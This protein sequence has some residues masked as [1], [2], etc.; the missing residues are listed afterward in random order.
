MSLMKK[1]TGPPLDSGERAAAV[2]VDEDPLGA[3]RGQ[4]DAGAEGAVAGGEGDEAGI[5]SSAAGLEHGVEA[6]P[7]ARTPG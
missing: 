4:R 7:T 6:H 5:V 2:A 1:R 3:D